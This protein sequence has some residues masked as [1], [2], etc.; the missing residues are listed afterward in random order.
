M[1]FGFDDDPLRPETTVTNA[2]AHRQCGAAPTR[3]LAPSEWTG[4]R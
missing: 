2:R 3:I 1:D 4:A